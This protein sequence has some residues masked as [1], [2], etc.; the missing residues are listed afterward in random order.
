MTINM[1]FYILRS[2]HL[3]IRNVSDKVVQKI[4]AFYVQKLV[5]ENRAAN[6]IMWKHG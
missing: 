1:H 2:I 3:R 5:F 6:E 4:K